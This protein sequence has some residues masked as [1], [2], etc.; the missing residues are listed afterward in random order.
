[1]SPGDAQNGRSRQVLLWGGST[2]LLAEVRRA[3]E[4]AAGTD[5]EVRSAGPGEAPERVLAEPPDLVIVDATGAPGNPEEI[6][7]VVEALGEARIAVLALLRGGDAEAVRAAYEAGAGDVLTEPIDWVAFP[8]RAEALA[9]GGHREEALRR[10]RDAL[11]HTQR[12]GRVGSWEL[13]LASGDM[14]LS[15]EACRILGVPPEPGRLPLEDLLQRLPDFDRVGLRRTLHDAVEG[16]RRFLLQHRLRMPDGRMCHLE[17]AGEVGFVGEKATHVRGTL[18]DVTEQRETERRMRR[19]ANFDALTGLATRHLF[20]ARL[21]E[22]IDR[23]KAES[24][25]IGLLYLDLDQF[26]RINDTLGHTVGDALLQRIA[27]VLRSHLRPAE[28]TAAEDPELDAEVSRL[29]GDE[30][31]VLLCRISRPEDAGEVAGRVLR[32]LEDPVVVGGREISTTASIGI[33][34]YPND[35]STAEA[36]LK[37]A[38]TAMYHAKRRGR[39]NFQFFQHSMGM[40]AMRRF[41]LEGELRHA[42]EREQLE[43]HF[44]PRVSLHTGRIQGMEALVRWEHPELGSVQ[45]KEF[46]PIAEETGLIVPI[47]AWV[48]EAAC[49]EAVSL[50]REGLGTLEVSVNVSS[51]QF[52]RDDVWERITGTLRDTGLDPHRLE[53]EIT[54]TL[55]LEAEADPET[56]LRDLRGIGVRVALDDFGTG[57]SSLSYVTRLPLDTVKLDRSIVRDVDS[58]PATASVARAVIA[59]AQTLGIHVVAEGVDAEGQARVLRQLGCSEMQGFLVAGALPPPD[60]RAFLRRRRS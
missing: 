18:R 29:G 55:M 26:K 39:A 44:Q 1:V 16:G 53:I 24:H 40:A 43:V 34:I 31:T 49:R 2:P 7:R 17:Q 58:D 10:E 15:P 32:S 3:L 38:D 54:E 13:D 28:R 48:L 23:A 19:L 42:L 25:L 56:L 20:L 47:G 50:Q 6:G 45:P 4:G 52:A 41:T 8:P 22:E 5:W 37:H 59:M 11:L 30:F 27:Q 33:A 35:A 36:L 12:L 14:R 57:Y 51:R 9:R 21:R 46:I 60:L